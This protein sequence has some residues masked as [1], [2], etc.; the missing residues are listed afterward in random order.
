MSSGHDE[1]RGG[2]VSGRKACLE[3][4]G[5]RDGRIDSLDPCKQCIV[6]GFAVTGC[7]GGQAFPT[8]PD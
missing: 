6:S 2:I 8:A 7:G 3:T 1:K 4:E 5:V